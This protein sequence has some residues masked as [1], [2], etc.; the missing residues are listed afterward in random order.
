MKFKTKAE[1][2]KFIMDNLGLVEY[3]ISKK[4]IYFDFDNSEFSKEDIR[5]IGILG[6][7]KAVDKYDTYRGY[8]FSS[9]AMRWIVGGI[10][11]S[12]KEVKNGVRYG[13]KMI[14][15]KH[16]VEEYSQTM[17][18]NNVRLNTSVKHQ[19]GE[20]LEMTNCIKSLQTHVD[21]DEKFRINEM[22]SVLTEKEKG[23]VIDSVFNDYTQKELGEK[24]GVCQQQAGKILK[25]ALNKIKDNALQTA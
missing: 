7:I 4:L 24:Y 25:K 10:Y 19:E 8:S 22:L 1:R 6:L 18:I 5:Q 16:K 17:N 21:Y 11:N 23:I 9:Y 3:A 2:E 14:L 12:I 13:R 20:Q 15:N